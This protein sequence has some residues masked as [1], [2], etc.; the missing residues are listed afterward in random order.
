MP[1]RKGKAGYGG[2]GG[3]DM[4]IEAIEPKDEPVTV[5]EA[6][7]DPAD[8]ARYILANG[9]SGASSPPMARPSRIICA[10]RAHPNSGPFPPKEAS[11][12]SS[13][14]A[15]ASP[16][17]PG[18]RI[19]RPALWRGQQRQRAGELQSRH[20]RWLEE[21]VLIPAKDGAFRNFGDFRP[22]DSRCYSPR[23]SAMATISTLHRNARRRQNAGEGHLGTYV[24]AV[25]QTDRRPSSPKASARIPTS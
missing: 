6:G 16:S 10:S 18:R 8:I 5:G 7:D 14:S 17:S 13:P 9:A 23:P 25:S 24:R 3:A 19:H 21:Q 2:A 15:T 12:N 22:T 1:P 20:G 11:Q 4:S